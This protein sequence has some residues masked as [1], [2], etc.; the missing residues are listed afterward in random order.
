[1]KVANKDQIKEID[2]KAMNNFKIPGSVLMENA[3]IAVFGEVLKKPELM[4]Q[5][6]TLILCGTGN[7]GGDGFCV[8]RHVYNSGFDVQV[9]I[10][11]DPEKISGDALLQ[12]DIIREMKIPCATLNGIGMPAVSESIS[13]AG[14]IID[15]IYGVGF[16]GEPSKEVL[17]IIGEINASKKYVVSVDIPSC[18][19]AD[20]GRVIKDAVMA[21][22]TVT[23]S[24]AK[25]GI[26]LYPGYLYAGEVELYPISIPSAVIKSSKL[27]LNVL[28][29]EE[30]S[31]LVPNRFPY[32]NKGHYG[33]GVLVAGSHKMPGAVALAAFA[34]YK[35]GLGVAETCIPE[36][37]ANCI[38]TN[39]V[40]AVT[41]PLPELDGKHCLKGA[42]DLKVSLSRAN[43]VAVGP[44]MGT[45]GEVK[46]VVELVLKNATCPII[47]DADGI[48]AIAKCPE[49]LKDTAATVVITPHIKE[50]SR[51]SGLTVDEIRED[52][53]GAAVNFAMD[54]GVTVVLKDARSV[55]AHPVS[56]TYINI[57]GHNA[58]A[59]GGSGD[60]LTGV[61]LALCAEGMNAYDASVLGSFIHGKAGEVAAAKLGSYGVM[62][63]DIAREIP[64]V[65]SA[66]VGEQCLQ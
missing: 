53:V 27:K 19:C 15:A 25:P 32:S 6:K 63:S 60:V 13:S 66:L 3:A 16:T 23:F 20:S 48:N 38:Q 9:I 7:N 39:V 52:I 14:V 18:V 42:G 45:G 12:Y 22:V 5:G 36:S 50:F 55:I 64:N 65:I 47:I 44:G 1:M 58:M 43:A 56:E 21:D 51:I 10:I 34:A 41:T 31:L 54:Y 33:R 37:I 35:S 46:E 59:K 8:A 28:T 24:L 30:A 40:E 11:G 29:E 61:I 26:L 4:I 57:T 49:V 2:Q 62:A 17:D